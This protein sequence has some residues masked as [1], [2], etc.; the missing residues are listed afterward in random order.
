ML[1]SFIDHLQ[2]QPLWV[3]LPTYLGFL[4]LSKHSLSFLAWLFATFL[5]PPIKDLLTAY[6]SWA[7]VTG[8][9]DGIGKAFAFQ[10]AAKG[11]NLILIS[12]TQAKLEAVSLQIQAQFPN[13]KIKAVA[14]DLSAA[15]DDDAAFSAAMEEALGGAEV[16]VLVNNAGATYP[17]ARYFDEVEERVWRREVVGVNVKGTTWVT[18]AVL[19]GMVKR[20]RGAV[21]N[22]GSGSALVVPSHPLFA[23][24]SASKA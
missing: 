10:L 3:A 4:L 20:R 1:S 17:A 12:R 2:R 8:A 9:T 22:V 19:P 21:V 11:L 14:L 5:R 16:G 23:I 6:G 24:Y 18:A 15:A 13:T 7:V